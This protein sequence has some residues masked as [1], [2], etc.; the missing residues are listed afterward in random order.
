M[1]ARIPMPTVDEQQAIQ[2][3]HA[4]TDAKFWQS[5]ANA[6]DDIEGHKG[7]LATIQGTIAEREKASADFTTHAQAA[8]DR[9]ARVEKGE[10][11][12]VPTPMTRKDFLRITGMTEAMRRHCVGGIELRSIAVEQVRR[13]EKVDR[14]VV[15]ELHRKLYGRP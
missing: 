8:K 3:A 10:A 12:A 7:F 4:R 15:R 13:R 2:L 11:V 6:A 9:L 5:V 1:H 14:A